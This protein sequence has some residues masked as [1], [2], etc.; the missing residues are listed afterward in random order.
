[1]RGRGR[2]WGRGRGRGCGQNRGRGRGRGYSGFHAGHPRRTPPSNSPSESYPSLKQHCRDG[3]PLGVL[4][5][6]DNGQLSTCI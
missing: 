6:C 1:M 2:G 3:D 4:A 5:S